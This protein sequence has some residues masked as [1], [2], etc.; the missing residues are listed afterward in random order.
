MK[1]QVENYIQ[2]REEEIGDE[3]LTNTVFLFF[4]D[5]S[6]M[7]IKNAFIEQKHSHY[8]VFSKIHDTLK[9]KFDR[10]CRD[11][12]VDRIVAFSEIKE[13]DMNWAINQI[14]KRT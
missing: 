13:R 10:T 7:M 14:Q 12:H 9:Y 5:G 11:S 4:E 2:K 1:N 8:I 3:E 6:Y